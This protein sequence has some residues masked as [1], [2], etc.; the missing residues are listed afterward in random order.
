MM[1]TITAVCTTSQGNSFIGKIKFYTFG[2][3]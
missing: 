1:P 3:K 2:F